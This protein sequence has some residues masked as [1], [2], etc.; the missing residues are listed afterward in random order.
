MATVRSCTNPNAPFINSHAQLANLATNYFAV[1]HPSLT[2]YLESVGGSNFGV[3]DDN[4]P[5]WHNPSCLTNLATALRPGSPLRR[6]S[7][8]S[9]A[10]GSEA[11]TPALDCSNESAALVA[12]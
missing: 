4:P 2:N 9:L 6:R 3:L 1:A 5:D 7:V 12:R 10:A 8:P 11:A